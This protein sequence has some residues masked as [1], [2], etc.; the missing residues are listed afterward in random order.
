[1]PFTIRPFRRFPVQCAVTLASVIDAA[2]AAKKNKN[3]PEAIRLF[4]RAIAM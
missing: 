3:F 2:E 4:G 1:M